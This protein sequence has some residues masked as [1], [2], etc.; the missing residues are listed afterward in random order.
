MINFS[1]ILNQGISSTVFQCVHQVTNQTFAAK[2][3]HQN[4]D[5]LQ[6]FVNEVN[7]LRIFEHPA[8]IQMKDYFVQN[9]QKIIFLEMCK[10]DLFEYIEMN[11]ILKIQEIRD[12]MRPIFEEIKFIHQNEAV[13]CDIKIENICVM[14][15][16]DFKLIDFGSCCSTKVE[17]NNHFGSFLYY[18]PEYFSETKDIQKCDIWS[19]GVTLFTCATGQ[20]PFGGND[21]EYFYQVIYGEPNFSFLEYYEEYKD[22][23]SLLR[24]MLMKSPNNRFSIEDCLSHPF[25]SKI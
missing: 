19:L 13:H 6:I 22:F 25:F 14:E 3:Y 1:K 21:S 18:P 20:F 23:L 2:V 9:D 17:Q 11:G 24:G 16:G 4:Q 15:N 12:K 8:I 10:F 5:N 7:W